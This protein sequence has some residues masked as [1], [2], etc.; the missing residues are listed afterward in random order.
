MPAHM[1]GMVS[2]MDAVMAFAREHNLKVIEDAA[3]AL[4]VSY[5]GR[6]AGT[7][8]DAGCFSFFADKTVTTGEG[9]FV[10]TDDENV[11]HNLLH[12]RNQGRPGRGTFVHSEIGFNFRMTDI[13]MAI[14]L[15]QLGKLEETRR[16]KL[17]ALEWYKQY[18]VDVDEVGFLDLEPGSE[19]IPFRACLLAERAHDLMEFMS[20]REIQPRTFFYPLHRQP[21]FDYLGESQDLSD[22]RFP[23]ANHGYEHGI[24]LPVFPTLAEEQVKYVA[25]VIKDFYAGRS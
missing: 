22:E 15:V 1:Y 3:Q 8:G 4:G 11:H 7:F 13:Q 17:R 2:N 16:R 10:V 19:R 18:L 12:L 14:G 24:C 21:C 20:E 6:H 25:G 23:N 9:G 5:K